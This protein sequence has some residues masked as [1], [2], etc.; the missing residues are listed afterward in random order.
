MKTE[1]KILKHLYNSKN[2]NQ[3]GRKC[4]SEENIKRIFKLTN[5][6]ISDLCGGDFVLNEYG[7]M[8]T[9]KL[10]CLTNKGNKFVKNYYYELIKEF[11]YW[12]FGLA[13]ILAAVFAII[14]VYIK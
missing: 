9:K 7:D 11:F 14:A 3:I 12:I 13:T 1:I 4:D 8:S 6:E 10:L 2:R 5:D